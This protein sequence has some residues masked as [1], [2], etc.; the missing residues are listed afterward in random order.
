MYTMVVSEIG[1]GLSLY[2]AYTNGLYDT[3]FVPADGRP[4]RK[5]GSDDP[6]VYGLSI[7]ADQKK[8]LFLKRDADGLFPYSL[9]IN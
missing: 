9:E 6:S 7:T 1:F 4:P 5:L 3:V 2:N 8:L